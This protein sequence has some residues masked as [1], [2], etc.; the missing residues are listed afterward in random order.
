MYNYLV[1]CFIAVKRR[2]GK[3]TG[4]NPPEKEGGGL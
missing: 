1:Y 2:Y 3:I 4:R